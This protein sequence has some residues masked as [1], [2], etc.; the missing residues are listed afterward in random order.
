MKSSGP[1]PAGAGIGLRSAHHEALLREQPRVGW[2]E[3]HTENYFH[4]GGAH[5]RALAHAGQ[6]TRGDRI[7]DLLDGGAP[8]IHTPTRRTFSWRPTP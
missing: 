7:F 2:I 8:V 5:V 6:E 3:V 1:I 4:E